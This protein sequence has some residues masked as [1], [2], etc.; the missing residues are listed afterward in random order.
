[1]WVYSCVKTSSS[2]SVVLP[3]SVSLDGGTTAISIVS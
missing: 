2:Q 3:I 1:M